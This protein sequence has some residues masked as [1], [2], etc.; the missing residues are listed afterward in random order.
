MEHTLFHFAIP[1]DSSPGTKTL[2][3]GLEMFADFFKRPLLWG[4]AADRELGAVQSEFELNRKDDE[5]RLS[6]V[7]CHT[8]GMDGMADPMGGNAEFCPPRTEGDSGEAAKRP[9]HPF[10]KFSWGNE[11]SLRI[12]PESS[13]IDVLK[14][15][16]DHY[17]RHYYARNMRLVVMA[18]Y[19][20]DEIEQRVRE[21]FRDVPAEP[22]LPSK[23]EGSDPIAGRGITNLEGYGL[24]FHPSSLGRVHRIVPVRDHHTLT[25]TWQFPPLREH[26]RTKP[27]DLIG[28]LIGHEASGSVLSVLKSRKYAMGLS[29]GVGDE[30]LS[31]AS[32]HALF[33]VDVSLSKRG[34]RNWE[35]VV[36]VIFDYIG[37]LR[38]HFLDGDEE[39]LPDW[40]YEELRDV[41]SSS[42]RFADEGDVS[43]LDYACLPSTLLP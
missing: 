26:W 39:C 1:Q 11:K 28:H 22:R 12:D 2:W 23:D 14:E 41:A 20:L 30:G 35:E 32:T 25:L 8:C 10:A 9:P 18:G 3:K 27:A 13:G 34:V 24:P 37:M 6:Q 38:G 43:V 16:R 7:M 15:L 17:D 36:K 33:E 4:N 42:Y 29:A 31:D 19:E 40:I 5:C 21:H